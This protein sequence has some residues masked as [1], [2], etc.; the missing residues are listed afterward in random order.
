MESFEFK[1]DSPPP[2]SDLKTADSPSVKIIS[3][4]N[5]YFCGGCRGVPLISYSPDDKIISTECRRCKIKNQITI[6]EFLSFNPDMPCCTQIDK[7]LRSS[8]YYCTEC[9]K[10][11]CTECEGIH[12]DWAGQSHILIEKGFACQRVCEDKCNEKYLAVKYCKKCGM[13]IC[14]DCYELRHCLHSNKVL[15]LK[16]Y[17]ND[18]EEKINSIKIL[19]EDINKILKES[20]EELTFSISEEERTKFLNIIEFFT[21]L[22]NIHSYTKYILSFEAVYNI[23]ENNYIIIREAKEFN[24]KIHPEEN[25]EEKKTNEN[26]N[27]FL[28]SAQNNSDSNPFLPQN[29]G[30]QLNNPFIPQNDIQNNPQNISN[31]SNQPPVQLE[32]TDIQNT[33]INIPSPTSENDTHIAIDKRTYFIRDEILDDGENEVIEFKNYRFN[34]TKDGKILIQN[35]EFVKFNIKKQICGFLNFLGG[36]L[37]LGITDGKKVIGVCMTYRQRDSFK[38]DLINLI[39]DTITPNCETKIKVF[40]IPVEN[41]FNKELFVIKIVIKQ[42]D[43]GIRYMLDDGTTFIGGDA[44]KKLIKD[45]QDFKTDQLDDPYFVSI[46]VK[47]IDDPIPKKFV[48]HKAVGV[49]IKGLS[50]KAKV[51]EIYKFFESEIPKRLN[52]EYKMHFPADKGLSKGFGFINSTTAE[53]SEDIMKAFKDEELFGRKIKMERNNYQKV[54]LL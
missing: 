51:S 22:F 53:E 24:K 30:T 45:N 18:K 33:I 47:E 7:H 28:N 26:N 23:V 42:G 20:P 13:Q 11:M 37:Y 29:D 32:S 34:P 44:R 40:F 5:I 21:V 41:N 46:S 48:T 38:N 27:P 6:D 49:F 8:T 14:G 43:R 15:S 35:D 1:K 17:C 50:F 9:G 25:K 12:R 3:K 52:K 54:S 36:R 39:R 31:D 4:T 19:I 10:F 16:K 2:K